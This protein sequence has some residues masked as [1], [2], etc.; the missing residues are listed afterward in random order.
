MAGKEKRIRTIKFLVTP[1]EDRMLE[2]AVA[3]QRNPK[4]GG[5][6]N[7]S[8]YYRD[9]LLRW[10]DSEITEHAAESRRRR[11]ARARARIH[12]GKADSGTGS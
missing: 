7:H 10:A 2:K 8:G 12:G 3:L 1:T 4:H 9:H 6:H 11:Q 5:F